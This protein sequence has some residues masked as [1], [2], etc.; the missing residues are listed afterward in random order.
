MADNQCIVRFLHAWPLVPLFKA[1]VQL[2]RAG[3]FCDVSVLLA[4]QLQ[5]FRRAVA[6]PTPTTMCISINAFTLHLHLLPA[7]HLTCDKH[8]WS[9]VEPTASQFLE[10]G[11]PEIDELIT[12][13]EVS[14]IIR[15]G[16]GPGL[17][18]ES[19]TTSLATYIWR[20]E[21]LLRQALLLERRLDEEEE[22]EEGEE[23]L[24]VVEEETEDEE[25]EAGE[26]LHAVL[27][28][29]A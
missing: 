19:T 9:I 3:T 6:L 28:G 4:G 29:G 24:L 17:A 18:R 10:G 8:H 12:F 22:V 20:R 13:L 16:H 7:L 11:V 27:P 14:R 21:R 2:R 23:Q 26:A 5:D 1:P 25:D 15:P